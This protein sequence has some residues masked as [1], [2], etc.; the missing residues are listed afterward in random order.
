MHIMGGHIGSLAQKLRKRLAGLA[1]I[2]RTPKTFPCVR[3][4]E[5][6][7][8]GGVSSTIVRNWDF[9]QAVA[10]T[11]RRWMAD[12]RYIHLSVGIPDFATCGIRG[13]MSS[14][15][16]HRKRHQ[17][18][19]LPSNSEL[20]AWV[21]DNVHQPNDHPTGEEIRG[22]LPETFSF[23]CAQGKFGT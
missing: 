8:A 2:L 12:I 14:K 6:R 9:F 22:A 17:R 3:T 18:R 21:G 11:A 4:H 16:Y 7:W 5:L 23:V 1:P 19:K 20:Q 10:S 15:A 13:E